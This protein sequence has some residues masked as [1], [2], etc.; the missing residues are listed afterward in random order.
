[1]NAEC[2]NN[3]ENEII[4]LS[5]VGLSKTNNELI[6]SAAMTIDN[7]SVVLTDNII[8]KVLNRTQ[9]SHARMNINS[10]T[11]SRAF[12]LIMRKYEAHA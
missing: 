8:I 3:L 2:S 6:V 9:E 7:G 1:M 10:N 4:C 12:S 5:I 11:K